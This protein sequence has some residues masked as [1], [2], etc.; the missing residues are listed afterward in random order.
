LEIDCYISTKKTNEYVNTKDNRPFLSPF[1]SAICSIKHEIIKKKNFYNFSGT[2][3]SLQDSEVIINVEPIIKNDEEEIEK[4]EKEIKIEEEKIKILKEKKIE[5][6][7]IE[8]KKIKKKENKSI[9][10]I[11]ITLVIIIIKL[12]FKKNR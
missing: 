1:S 2:D 8:E 6:K 10:K 12:L 9:K 4:I 7:K 5:E 3:L 11:F